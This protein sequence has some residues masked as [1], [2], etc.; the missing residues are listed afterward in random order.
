MR[1]IN[2]NKKAYYEYNVIEKYIAGIK[3]LGSEVKPLRNHEVSINE[4]YCF[5]DNGEIFIKNMYIKP[6]ETCN[7]YDNHQPYRDRK[8]LLNKKEILKL[9][10]SIESKG[11]TIIPLDLHETKTGLVKITL[12]LCKGK[13]LHDKRNT[14]KER[15]ISRELDR[16]FK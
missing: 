4:S 14:I 16:K 10:T 7:N 13:K 6:N 8:L 12:G 9:R 5:I 3:L 11:M 2:K 1:L 15:D